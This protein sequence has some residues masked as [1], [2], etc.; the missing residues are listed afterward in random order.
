MNGGD[1]GRMGDGLGFALAAI[2]GTLAV[3]VPFGCW[4]LVEIGIWLWNKIP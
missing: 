1:Y 2:I 3:F 4:K